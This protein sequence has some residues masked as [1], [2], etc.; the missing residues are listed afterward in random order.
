MR[1]GL[2]LGGGGAVGIAWENGVLAGL[3]DGCGF[4]PTESAVIVGTSA[5]SAVGADMALRKDPHKA[6]DGDDLTAN[7]RRT[8]EPPD[9]EKGAF[10]EVIGLMMSPDARTPEVVAQIGRLAIEADTA[11]G[12]DEF[13][14]MFRR[15]VGAEEWPSVD[16]RATSTCCETGE[17]VVWSS[18]DDVDLSV[19]VASSCAIPGFFPAVGIHGNHYMDGNRGKNYHAAIVADLDLDAAL[20]IGPKIAVPG[21]ERMTRDDMEAIA[22]LGVRCHTILG[23]ERLDAAGLNLMDFSSRAIGF[24]IGVADGVANAEAVAEMLR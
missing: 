11:M 7:P 14:E 12:Q 21:V 3:V 1:T 23:S 4:D 22:S 10:A 16:F 19:A 17:P 8:L 2:L 9:L 6:L 5:G 24:E 18:S 13:V 15:T 20:F